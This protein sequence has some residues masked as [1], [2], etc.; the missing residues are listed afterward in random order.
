MEVLVAQ[1][2][3]VVLL[4]ISILFA[5]SFTQSCTDAPIEVKVKAE[6]LVSNWSDKNVLVRT[7]CMQI[8]FLLH[9]D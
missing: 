9:C 4:I 5:N 1:V 2:F 8:S 6:N 7:L 3:R